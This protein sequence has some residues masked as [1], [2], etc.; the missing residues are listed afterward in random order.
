MHSGGGEKQEECVISE[1]DEVVFQRRREWWIGSHSTER[2]GKDRK[3]TLS[4]GKK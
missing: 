1:L 4:F 3:L 2:S